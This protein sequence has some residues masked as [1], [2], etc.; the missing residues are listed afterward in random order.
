[1]GRAPGRPVVSYPG[2]SLVDSIPELKAVSDQVYTFAGLGVIATAILTI[3]HAGALHLSGGR[4]NPELF[5]KQFVK[6]G[7]VTEFRMER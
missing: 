2:H 3:I 1:M 6:P 5:Q 7:V 4:N